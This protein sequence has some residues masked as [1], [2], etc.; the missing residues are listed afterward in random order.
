MK[1]LALNLQSVKQ[2]LTQIVQSAINQCKLATVVTSGKNGEGT[3]LQMHGKKCIYA[4]LVA[5]VL[6]WIHAGKLWGSWGYR[7][8]CR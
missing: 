8:Q 3:V 2:M 5:I 4:D 7:Q 1:P 6:Q